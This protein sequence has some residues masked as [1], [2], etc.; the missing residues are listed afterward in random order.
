[1]SNGNNRWMVEAGNGASNMKRYRNTGG[2]A[3]GPM[4]PGRKRI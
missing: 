3:V 4:A 1:M 2:M